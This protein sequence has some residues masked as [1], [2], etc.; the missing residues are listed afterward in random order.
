MSDNDACSVDIRGLDAL[1]KAL[2]V[3]LPVARVG[4][5]GD[6]NARKEG[7][8]TNAEVGA[9]HEFGAPARNLPVRSFLRMPIANNLNKK[10]EASQMFDKEVLADV[11]K[12]GTIRPWIEKVAILGQAC[13]LESFD[14]EGPGWAK[15]KNP[16]YTNNAN[17]ILDDTGQLKNSVT[18]DIE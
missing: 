7:T 14:E 12:S 13:S 1:L 3:N 15:W 18:W 16:D 6:K 8:S 17:K 10:L 5:L 2:K 11:I 9:A 4:I